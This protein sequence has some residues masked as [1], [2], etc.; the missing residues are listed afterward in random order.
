MSSTVISCILGAIHSVVSYEWGSKLNGGYQATGLFIY[1][2]N[3][4]VMI[5]ID[6]AR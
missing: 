6:M 1:I 5:S 2:A 3:D 4:D